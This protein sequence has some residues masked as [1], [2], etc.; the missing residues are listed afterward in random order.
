LKANRIF[1]MKLLILLPLFLIV[2]MSI[3][4]QS[5]GAPAPID[6]GGLVKG[7]V[8]T[9][10]GLV[11]GAVGT[12]GGLVKGVVGTAGGVVKG[13][14]NT[15]GGV[16]KEVKDLA[17]RVVGLVVD[18]LG[19]LTRVRGVDKAVV[20]FNGGLPA[21][22]GGV[23]DRSGFVVNNGKVVG[24]A[25]NPAG[26]L[27]TG[28]TGLVVDEAGQVRKQNGE[29]AGFVFGAVGELGP[30]NHRVN[31]L[32]RILNEKN[33]VVG[34]VI[35]GRGHLVAGELNA[36][37]NTKGE[38][39]DKDGKPIGIAVR[40]YGGGGAGELG[41]V[42]PFAI[43]KYGYVTDLTGKSVG[44]VVI[45]ADKRSNAQ[46]ELTFNQSGQVIDKSRNVV[47]RV[48]GRAGG[49]GPRHD[50]GGFN[51]FKITT[52]GYVLDKNNK[53]VGKVVNDSGDLITGVPGLKITSA[54]KAV[55]ATGQVV[56][57]VVGLTEDKK[58][59]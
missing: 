19:E 39:H 1:K 28:L 45:D 59:K 33:E 7:A 30:G 51:N 41:T 3:I 25:L 34:I 37:V 18:T 14:V 46:G 31:P 36:T 4:P 2:G 13:A 16:L 50:G 27:L 52:A 15:I 42:L 54:G 9:A 40:R 23:V 43:N 53:E 58:Q 57:R 32:G 29:V 44:K 22:V 48:V 26:H 55:T 6:V 56:G 10:G 38:V 20:K 17:G 11:K 49:A 24:V 8:G 5:E 21:V 12:A 47:G 35:N